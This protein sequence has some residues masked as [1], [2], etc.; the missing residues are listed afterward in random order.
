MLEEVSY[1]KKKMMRKQGVA[2]T[3]TRSVYVKWAIMSIIYL[4]VSLH[5]EVLQPGAASTQGV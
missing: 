4:G 3:L 2:K 1:R 5:Q